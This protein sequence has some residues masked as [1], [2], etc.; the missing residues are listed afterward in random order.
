MSSPSAP[1]TPTTYY[2]DTPDVRKDC[3]EDFKR[4]DKACEP[5][6]ERSDKNKHPVL[7]KMLGEKSVKTLDALTK[8]LKDKYPFTATKENQWMSHCDG[9]WIKP[10]S[11]HYGSELK[12]F[13]DTIKDMSADLKS[14]IES[15]LKPLVEKVG[16][17]VKEKAISA[18]KDKAVKVGVRSAARWGVALGGVAVGGVGGI[19]TEGV[20]TAWNIYDWGQ[21]GYQ[22][23]TLGVEA[24]GAIKEIGTVLEIAQ[25][26][27]SELADLTK[28]MANKTPTDLMADGMGVI[29]RLSACTRARRCKLVPYNKTDAAESLGGDGCCPGQTGHHV[30]PDEMTKDGNCEGYTKGS[31]PTVCV[32]GVNN[33]NGSH[34]MI[35]GNFDKGIQRHVDSFFGSKDSISYTKARDVGV[36][37][38]Q[39]TFPESKCDA[40]CLKAQLDAYY[41]TKCKKSLPPLSGIPKKKPASTSGN[42]N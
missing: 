31:A 11:Q 39:K 42:A 36:S 15:Q 6:H 25:T 35:H 19:V 40:K 20:A 2:I 30:L 41:N 9:L 7:R 18:A 5:E 21:T 14:A 23:A 26:A 12:Q 17:E 1:N 27:Q 34:K 4:I 8:K 29:S 32:E 22:A 13:N 3:K 28:G 24:Y 37:S 10:S 38:I 16:Q 33:G